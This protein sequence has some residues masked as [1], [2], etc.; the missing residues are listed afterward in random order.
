MDENAVERLLI[1]DWASGLRITTVPQA[2]HRLGFAD[3]LEIRWEMADRMDALWHSTLEAPEKIQAINSAIGMTT[4]EDRSPLLQHWRDQV[5]AWDRASILL[6][7]NEKL[8]ARHILWCQK[9]GSRLPSPEDIGAAV[10]IGPKETA[11]GI[12]MLAWLGFL[13]LPNSQAVDDYTLANGHDRFLD[14][15]GFSFHTV[16][17]DGDER[18][19]IP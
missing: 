14:G 18:F 19:G 3:D 1:N 5:G 7:D 12:K 11:D 10:D 15:L 16:T 6:T 4:D 8:M 2:M 13:T 9:H 17:L